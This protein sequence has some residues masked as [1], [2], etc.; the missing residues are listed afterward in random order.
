MNMVSPRSRY[1]LLIPTFNRPAY[2]RSLL[3]YLAARRFQYPV[4]VLELELG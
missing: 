3:G 1:T 4:H 2:L